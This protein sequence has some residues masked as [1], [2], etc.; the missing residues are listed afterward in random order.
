MDD[1]QRGSCSAVEVRSAGVT[2]VTSPAVSWAARSRFWLKETERKER[3][4][5]REREKNPLILTGHGL[6]IRV[7]KDCLLVRDGNTHYPA[8]RREW[9]FFNGEL[10]IPPALIVIDGSGE[11]T[12]DAID[13]LATQDV[14]LIRLRWDGQ[15]ASVVT[16]GGQAASTEK[17]RWQEKT[18]L[19]PKLRVAFSLD[20][21]QQKARNTLV[22]MEECL[23]RSSVWDKAYKNIAT[24]TRW[25]EQ[26]PPQRLNTLLGLEGAIANEYFRTWSGISLKW[27]A[28]KQHPIPDDWL[29]FRSRA[30]LRGGRRRNYRATHPVNAM[31]NYAYGV[32]TAR[33]QIRLIADGYDPTI[34]IMHDEEEQRGKYP[35][36]ALD[37]IEPMRPVVDR[38]VLHLVDTVTFTGTD[39][40][41]QHDGVCRLNPQ[42][43]RRV[44]Q[45][46]M[47]YYSSANSS[48]WH[49][50]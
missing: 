18:R 27:K 38:A 28:T 4:R 20:L 14:P 15:F 3:R 41:I 9:R 10:D 31:L 47:D 26:R 6:S 8:D 48:E 49:E 37:H 16:A 24:R 25:L 35:A 46:A 2:E 5:R 42:L 12:M 19:T 17:V 33:T 21:I 50:S 40:S 34:G 32:L 36:F 23:P 1:G 22:T 44:A 29:E 43:A 7:D 39:F 30:A 13:W 45:L 11:I